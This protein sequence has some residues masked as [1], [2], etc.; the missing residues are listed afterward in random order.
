MVDKEKGRIR[1]R[2][3]IGL[4]L[5]IVVVCIG[6]GTFA[7][8]FLEGLSWFEFQDYCRKV[9]CNCVVIGKH[10]GCC[11]GFSVVH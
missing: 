6:I 4:A 7:V 3:K 5:G 9:F 1:T 11:Q 2:S 10:I 8:H